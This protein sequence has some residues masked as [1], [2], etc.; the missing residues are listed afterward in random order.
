VAAAI[1]CSS[2][3]ESAGRIAIV[4]SWSNFFRAS[5]TSCSP[6]MWAAPSACLDVGEVRFVEIAEAEHGEPGSQRTMRAGVRRQHLEG[7]RRQVR[8]LGD[9]RELITHHVGRADRVAQRSFTGHRHELQRVLGVGQPALADHP[10]LQLR[11]QPL[12]AP[13]DDAGGEDRP[14]VV[15]GLQQA[16]H[17]TGH[18][19]LHQLG[20]GLELHVSGVV[21]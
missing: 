21:A 1:S 15:A 9:V 11:L 2:A 14:R 13:L 20:V 10:H 16:R 4:R 19:V 5:R 17:V 7:H 6:S 12:C 3:S 8:G 18:K